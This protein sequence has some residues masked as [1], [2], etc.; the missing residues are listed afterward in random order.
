M[1]NNTGVT[2]ENYYRQIADSLLKENELFK[3]QLRKSGNLC[4]SAP[5]TVSNDRLISKDNL[6]LST[7]IKTANKNVSREKAG[8]RHD[9]LMKVFAAY[10]KMIS[11]TL[12]YE[13]LHANLPLA[14]PSLSTANKFIHDNRPLA[15]EGKL[16]LEELHAYLTDRKLPLR[17]SLSEDATRVQAT[18]S[19]DP[20]TNQLVGFA[21]PL[22]ENGMPIPYSFQFNTS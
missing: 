2:N 3:K 22:D 4:E 21:L 20:K 12:T 17:V 8:Y 18:V 1:T 9:E 13:T 7:M 10:I 14:W 11:G 6:I 5:D 16:R 19:H 15:V